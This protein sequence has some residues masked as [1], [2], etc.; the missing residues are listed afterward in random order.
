MTPKGR[1]NVSYYSAVALGFAGA[2]AF[3]IERATSSGAM[4]ALGAM[5]ILG[6]VAL[7]VYNIAISRCPHCRRQ[8]RLRG[9]SA[10]CP[11]CGG[12]I[13]LQEWDLPP[14]PGRV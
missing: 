6:F 2:F 4:R 8:I 13:P 10:H 12:W 1:A 11:R 7:A 3:A 9:G 5:L 14:R